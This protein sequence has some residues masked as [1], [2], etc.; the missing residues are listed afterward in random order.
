MRSFI[1]LVVMVLFSGCRCLLSQIPPQYIYVDSSCTAELPN[2]VERVTVSDNCA[3]AT[4]IQTPSPGFLLTSVNRITNVKITATDVFD[5]KSE[6]NF[7][8][9]LIDT[10]PPVIVYDSL[11]ADMWQEV[12][13]LY[14]RADRMIAD[15]MDSNDKYFPYEDFGVIRDDADSTY[16]KR[17]MMT[18][19]GPGHAKTG[20]GY[21]FWTFPVPFD[22]IILDRW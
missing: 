11:L 21:R 10:M 9:T 16:Y 1:F 12:N 19:T 13:N 7:T 15:L 5:N 6:V 4:V 14:D 22:T 20:N 2:Y 18:W 17:I 3:L 8:V